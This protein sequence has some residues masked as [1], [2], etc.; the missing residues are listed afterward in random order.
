MEY[1][2]ENGTNTCVKISGLLTYTIYEKLTLS[3]GDISDLLCFFFFLWKKIIHT[4]V[5]HGF[6]SQS[7]LEDYQIRDYQPTEAC[8]E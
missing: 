1:I 7:T 5:K 6:T 3:F 2:S 4:S 8:A